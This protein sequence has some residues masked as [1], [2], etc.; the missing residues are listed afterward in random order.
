MFYLNKPTFDDLDAVT[1]QISIFESQHAIQLKIKHSEP[2]KLYQEYV[3]N[4]HESCPFFCRFVPV[5]K[6]A[7]RVRAKKCNLN[8][9]GVLLSR[10]S[11]LNV[12][13]QKCSCGRWQEFGYPCQDAMVYYWA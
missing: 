2:S 6:L 1:L 5:T 3:C 12:K 9:C 10:T 11:K 7:M 13:D 8:H 4:T